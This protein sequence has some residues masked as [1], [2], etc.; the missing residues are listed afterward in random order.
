[1]SKRD[2]TLYLKDILTSSEKILAYTKNMG[3]DE[4]FADSKTYD[5]VLRNLE[6]IGEAAKKCSGRNQAAI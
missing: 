2:W 4:F 1:M 3:R 6:I 5:A